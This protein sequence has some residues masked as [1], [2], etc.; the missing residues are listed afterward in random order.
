M[1]IFSFHP[2]KNIATGE[3][4]AITTNSEE[5]YQKL[6]ML[7]THGITKDPNILT[8][9]DGAWY[10]EQQML[11]F[12]YRI[13]DFQCAL[14]ISQ[15]KRLNEFAKKRRE[16]VNIYKELFSRDERFSFLKEKDYSKAAFHLCPLLIDFK[17]IKI[18]KKDL[19]N[20]LRKNGLNLQVHYIPVH[21][22][23]FY[24]S[25]GFNKG[26]YPRAEEYYQKTISLPLYYGLRRNDLGC[27]VNVIKKLVV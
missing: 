2:V 6:L 5:L 19:F 23:P 8:K 9:D 20:K 18:N 21:L 14:G 4:G 24:K 3:G 16:L 10:Y 7:R 13:T 25:L 12:N 27:I 26:D 17:K 1:A 11:G 15:L 22:Q